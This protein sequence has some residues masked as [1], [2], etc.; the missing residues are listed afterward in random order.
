MQAK[1]NTG[2]AEHVIHRSQAY[3]EKNGKQVH[4]RQRE[5]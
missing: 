3:T 4:P 1:K 5:L 2:N